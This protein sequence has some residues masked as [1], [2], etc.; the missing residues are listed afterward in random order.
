M[1]SNID[2]Y[3][4]WKDLKE[5]RNEE[6]FQKL[7]LKHLSLVKYH[8]G[9]IKM[10]VPGFIEEEDLISYG[11]IGL[12]DAINKFDH[13][14]GIQF[15]TYASRRIRGEI[16]DHLRKLDWL[17]HSLRR[18]ARRVQEAFEKLTKKTGRKPTLQ[19]LAEEVDIDKER[20]KELYFKLYSSQWVSLYDEVGDA[21]VLDLLPED[22]D[23]SPEVI[24][25]DQERVELLAEAIDR[26]NDTEKMVIAL[27]YYEE[28]TQKEIAEVLDLSPA[29]ISQIHKKAVYRLRGILG[30]KKEQLI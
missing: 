20:I 24:F 29:R 18:D 14:K 19:E 5:N 23:R 8:A 2:D 6:V 11:V 26:L 17:P 25:Q 22:R 21:R 28:L 12:I 13:Q 27:F 4:L 9:R 16:I 30:K 15:N 3:S 10:V 7:V 1:T